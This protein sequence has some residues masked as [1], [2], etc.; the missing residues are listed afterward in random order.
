M[1]RLLALPSPSA[2][3]ARP[4]GTGGGCLL[5]VEHLLRRRLPDIDDGAPSR[6]RGSTLD[7]LLMVCLPLRALQ[8]DRCRHSRSAHSAAIRSCT[9]IGRVAQMV[10]VIAM[11]GLSGT[12]VP[13]ERTSWTRARKL[14][15]ESSSAGMAVP[16][17]V[18]RSVQ[19]SGMCSPR[20]SGS[21]TD[22]PG[23]RL[24]SLATLR[25][26]RTI[27]PQEGGAT[28][29]SVPNQSGHQNGE[30]RVAGS[31]RAGEE[32]VL[33]AEGDHAVILPI[34]GKKL[35]SVIAGTRS[36]DAGF[37][38]SMSS[39]APAVRLF[40]SRCRPATSSS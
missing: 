26:R 9:S 27:W 2:A 10:G 33:A 35:K 4:A 14:P 40:M 38:G 32:P 21:S 25:I 23:P 18:D 15:G 13:S 39:G 16:P 36:M 12:T 28:R 31:F 5:V 3:P 34:S 22:R 24:P 29:R 6:W 11:I 37:D 1:T 17:F 8:L 7:G 20:P 19:V 30:H